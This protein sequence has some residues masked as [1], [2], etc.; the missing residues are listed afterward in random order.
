MLLLTN[1][2]LEFYSLCSSFFGFLVPLK[3]DCRHCTSTNRKIHWETKERYLPAIFT[4]TLVF[5]IFLFFC[6]LSSCSYFS[7]VFF[8]CNWTWRICTRD[9]GST[10]PKALTFLKSRVISPDSFKVFTQYINAFTYQCC[11]RISQSWLQ[12]SLDSWYL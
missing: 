11:S 3:Y 1:V 6:C 9:L 10:I 4:N 7:F 2:D 8:T 12:A 5:I